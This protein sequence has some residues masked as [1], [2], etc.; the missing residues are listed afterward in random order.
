MLETFRSSVQQT[1][2]AFEK[3]L[4]VTFLEKIPTGS[5]V[6]HLT[7]KEEDVL[8]C[9]EIMLMLEKKNINVTFFNYEFSEKLVGRDDVCPHI[10]F[11]NCNILTQKESFDYLLVIGFHEGFSSFIMKTLL[12]SCS[13][14]FSTIVVYRHLWR[15]NQKWLAALQPYVDFLLGTNFGTYVPNDDY[16][17]F[18]KHYPYEIDFVKSADNKDLPYLQHI[19]V[20]KNMEYDVFQ[21][22]VRCAND[23]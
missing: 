7:M 15:R 8:V 12:Q 14:L 23:K 6:A 11:S 2:N 13:S 22:M 10:F 3:E 20:V 1:C 21:I 4:L 18:L 16:L 9:P 17:R 5:S 19:P